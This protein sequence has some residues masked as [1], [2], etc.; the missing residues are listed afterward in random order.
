MLKE[1][2]ERL[3]KGVKERQEEDKK[4]ALFAERFLSWL[5]DAGFVGQSIFAGT[6]EK[7]GR[8]FLLLAG[9]RGL[10]LGVKIIGDDFHSD[11]G[12]DEF[13]ELNASKD[14]SGSPSSIYIYHERTEFPKGKAINTRWG[15][16]KKGPVRAARQ[17]DTLQNEDVFEAFEGVLSLNP[18]DVARTG[19]FTIA[20]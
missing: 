5:M 17:L 10:D 12:V 15:D 4:Y 9:L 16:Y 19:F 1:L 3:V 14:Y 6:I 20:S 7:D 18:K 8:V 2:A 11:P 13:W